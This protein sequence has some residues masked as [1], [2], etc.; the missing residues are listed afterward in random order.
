MVEGLVGRLIVTGGRVR[1]VWDERGKVEAG[2]S[3]VGEIVVGSAT[4]KEAWD[5]V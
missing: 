2:V 4:L 3:P 1:L 5:E